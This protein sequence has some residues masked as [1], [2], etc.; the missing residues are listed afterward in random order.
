YMDPGVP[1][2]WKMLHNFNTLWILFPSFVTAFTILAS[3]ELAGRARGATG[4]FDWLGKLPWRD[5]LVSSV[6]LSMILFAVGGLGGAVNASSP[7][8]WVVNN[9]AWI[10]AHFPRPVGTAPALTFMG[11]AYWLVPRLLGKELELK[12]M[13]QVQPYLWFI[14]MVLFSIA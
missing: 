14:G 1:A 4:L 6:L 7:T 8:T 2:G 9:P 13:A 12:P 10:Q 11:T 3:L 5:P